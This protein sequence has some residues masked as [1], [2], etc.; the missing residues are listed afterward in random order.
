[1]MSSRPSLAARVVAAL[2]TPLL[3]LL[4][5]LISPTQTLATTTTTQC[6]GLLPHYHT[7]GHTAQQIVAELGLAPNVEGGYY[8]ESFRDAAPVAPGRNRSA[9]TAIYYLL[10][11]P[12]VPSAWHRVLDAAE[13]WH[14]YAGAPLVLQLSGNNGTATRAHVLGPDV[15]SG[16]QRPQVVV[17]ADE[18]Q[19]AISCGE[20]TLVGTTVAPAFDPN[21]YELAPPG[22]EPND[23]A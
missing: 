10:E 4:P 12:D 6:D 8:V 20:W 23:G 17:A 7:I 22:W 19:R 18:W 2:A 11:G 16:G 13:V 1:M 9:S 21:A 14:Y 5:L 3:L 15:F